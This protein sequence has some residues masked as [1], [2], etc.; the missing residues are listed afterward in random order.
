KIGVGFTQENVHF[1]D[2]N[3]D[4]RAEIAT[5]RPDGQVWAWQNTLGFAENPFGDHKV[6]ADG[7]TNGGLHLI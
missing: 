6:I 7:F 2:L 1:G 5:V 3:G 4:G